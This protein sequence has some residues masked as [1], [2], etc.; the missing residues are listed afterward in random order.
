MWRRYWKDVE[1]SL[2]Q[3]R[4]WRETPED[5]QVCSRG[6]TGRGCCSSIDL[7]GLIS[8]PPVTA[9]GTCHFSA[10]F[11]ALT[12]DE[13][14]QPGASFPVSPPRTFLPI[15]QHPA[16]TRPPLWHVL[17][18]PWQNS[19]VPPPPRPL[20]PT[21]FASTSITKLLTVDFK[22]LIHLIKCFSVLT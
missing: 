2:G 1:T 21:H 5:P 16:Q 14:S 13:L 11:S 8:R 18:F 7:F 4:S 6:R 9:D 3:K 22:A 15:F 20:D 17:H 19:S 12:Q 10:L